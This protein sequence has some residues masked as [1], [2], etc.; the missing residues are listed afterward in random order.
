M[1]APER[2]VL[3]LLAAGRSLRFGDDDKLAA[4]FLGQPLAMHVVTALEDV[5]FLARVAITSGT[6]LDFGVRGYREIA[7]PATEE[8]LS[9]SVRLGV[10]AAQAAG[11]AA[12][13]IALADMPRV[14]AAHIYRL[15][16]AAEG[17]DFV[18]ASSDGVQPGPPALFAEARFAELAGAAGDAGGRAMIRGGV[19]IIASPD[20]LIDVDTPDD[21]A[22]LRALA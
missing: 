5:P 14:T 16:D 7:N 3:V 13:L 1:I 6:A 15:L 9:G 11:A 12:M 8:G 10:A 20:E 18:V 21:L 19:H 4:D 22:R 17:T 2:T